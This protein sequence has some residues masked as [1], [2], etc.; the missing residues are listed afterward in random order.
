MGLVGHAALCSME[1]LGLQSSGLDTCMQA[2]AVSL[3]SCRATR[4]VLQMLQWR[5]Q[6][7]GVC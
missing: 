6:G 3:W 1:Q 2:K 5:M 4:T 7:A